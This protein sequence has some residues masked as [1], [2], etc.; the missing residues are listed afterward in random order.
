PD[1]TT[2]AYVAG[3]PRAP[4]GAS[5]EHALMYW[6]TL[7][8]DDGAPFDAEVSLDARDIV[9]M[10]TW[11]T[12]PEQALPV[13][14]HVPDPASIHDEAHRAAIIRAID[15]MGLNAGEALT[16]VKID[17]VFIGSCTNGRIEDL[18]AAAA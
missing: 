3:K 14:G 5:F 18:R 4:K 17:R 9:P 15:Y 10:V 8:S 13:T 7:K 1:E 16:E 12:S 11:G 2:F 6:R